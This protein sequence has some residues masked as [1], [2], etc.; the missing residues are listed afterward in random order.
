M[1]RLFINN[2]IATRI[3]NGKISVISAFIDHNVFLP[4]TCSVTNTNS[5]ILIEVI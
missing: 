1:H 5:H 3:S 4:F 2:F